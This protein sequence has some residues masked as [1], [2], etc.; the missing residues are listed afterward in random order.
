M[1]RDFSSKSTGVVSGRGEVSINSANND[2]VIRSTIHWMDG[3]TVSD[4]VVVRAGGSRAEL[5]LPIG[6][7]DEGEGLIYIKESDSRG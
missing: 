7:P 2:W 4:A 3:V 1:W 5:I 6:D